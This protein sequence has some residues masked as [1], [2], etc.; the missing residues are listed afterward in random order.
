MEIISTLLSSQ[1]LKITI[2]FVLAMII[3]QIFNVLKS[4]FIDNKPATFFL[5]KYSFTPKQYFFSYHELEFYRLLSDFLCQNHPW[6][7]SIFPK[8]RLL[9]LAD[10]KYKIN[11]NKISSK[12][13]DFLIV[14]QTKHC[15]PIL[16]IELNWPSHETKDMHDRDSFVAEF[17]KIIDINFLT[18]H[19]E[20]IKNI[21]EISKK[22][23]ELLK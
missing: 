5:N 14:D 19:N 16:A 4:R 8:V 10:T 1:L 20:E 2:I 21:E 11:Y 3:V 13:I 18:I 9:D 23:N 12:H 17:F 15:S 6:K 22:I 7:Y